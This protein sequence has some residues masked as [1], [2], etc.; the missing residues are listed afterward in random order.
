MSNA[1]PQPTESKNSSSTPPK[2][3]RR[4]VRAAGL[5]LIIVSVLVG[6]FMLIAFLG[7]Q[8]GQRELQDKQFAQLDRQVTLAEE[9]IGQGN[10]QLALT[11]LDWVLERDA[12]HAKAQSLREQ[13]LAGIGTTPEPTPVTAV[14]VTPAP[15]RLPTATPGAI[16][17]PSEELLRIQRLVA[18]KFWEEALPALLAFQQ[19]FP[20]F[21]RE[22][23]DRLLYD[24][25][26]NYGLDLVDG[27]Q[28]ELGM[29]YLAQAQQLGD[30]PQY[31]KDYQTWAELY[32][33]GISFY[34]VN[35][36]ASAYYF[37]DLCLAAPFYQSSCEQLF[38]VLVSLGDQ[39]AFAQDWCPAEQLYRE[40]SSYQTTAELT[41]KRTEATENCLLATPTPSEP[42]TD[43]VPISDTAP[44][45]GAPFVLPIET[46]A[47]P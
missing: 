25:F 10:Y 17:S 19:Q 18:T 47:S 6:W 46:P 31:V 36:E 4:P 3:K 24:T 21:E 22:E 15:T 38:T 37:R 14:T 16:D 11:R 8:S 26:L 12:N 23:T 1:V 35:W 32:T 13:A 30:L 9:N 42:I 41:Q 34:G 20:S 45:E 33:Q 27:E 44:F 29:Y 40:A 7:W 28:V 39:Y 5:L 2:K 43:T